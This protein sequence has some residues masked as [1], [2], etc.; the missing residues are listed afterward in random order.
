MLFLSDLFM[1]F[2]SLVWSGLVWSVFLCCHRYA[3]LWQVSFEGSF[4]NATEAKKITAGK[5]ITG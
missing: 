2:F 5:F 1:I 3:K 4:D